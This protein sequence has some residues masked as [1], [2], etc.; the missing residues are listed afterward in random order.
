MLYRRVVRPWLGF[1]ML[2]LNDM[3]IAQLKERDVTFPNVKKGVLVAMVTPG[4][5]AD[6]AGFHPGDVVIEFDGKPVESIKEIIEIMSDRIGKAI[7]VV[8]KRA[9]DETAILT[10]I[11]EE[12][13]PDM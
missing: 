9:N 1:K 10:V 13:N 8:V 11:P 12:A 2:D 7:K 4:S 3:I 6:C 5:P